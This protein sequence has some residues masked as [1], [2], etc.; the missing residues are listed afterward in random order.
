MNF[1]TEKMVVRGFGARATQIFWG[2]GSPEKESL[3]SGAVA[4]SIDKVSPLYIG[5]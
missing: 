5:S 4:L 1:K 3:D 2:P